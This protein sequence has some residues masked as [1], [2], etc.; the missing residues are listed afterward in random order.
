MKLEH[1]LPKIKSVDRTQFLVEKA[2]D[3]IVL[4]LGCVDSG[5]LDENLASGGLLHIELSKVAKRV[6]GVDIDEEGLD[7]L[8]ALGMKDLIVGDVEH[9][10]EIEGLSKCRVDII[11]AGEIIEHLSNPGLFLRSCYKSMSDDTLLIITTPNPFFYRNFVFTLLGREII[12]PDHNFYFSPNALKNFLEREKL[13]VQSM[14][15]YAW[16]ER[17][18]AF[19]KGRS[20]LKN[21]ARC[22]LKVIDLPFRYIIDRNW[23]FFCPG[24]IVVA[25]KR[26]T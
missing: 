7:R 18:F 1:T 24:L 13:Q 12:H 23:P 8:R 22:V 10:D 11:V 21:A 26:V 9:L 15:A 4:H 5:F 20:P 3:R 16:R 17:L 14:A 19:K 25:K 2:K 6:Y